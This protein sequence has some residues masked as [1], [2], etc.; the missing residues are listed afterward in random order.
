MQK[1]RGGFTLELIPVNRVLVIR[2]VP[3]PAPSVRRARVETEL[4]HALMDALGD[5]ITIRFEPLHGDQPWLRSSVRL[6]GPWSTSRATVH[7]TVASV[8]SQHAHAA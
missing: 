8:L 4:R 3:D 2:Y 6:Y 5:D 7:A 1:A